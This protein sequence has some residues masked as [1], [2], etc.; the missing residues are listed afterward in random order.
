[1]V[2]VA[3]DGA[4][5]MTGLELLTGAVYGAAPLVCVLRDGK[6][7]Q[8]A[9]FQKIP[10]NRETCSVLPDYDLEH[11]AAATGCRYFRI[12]VDAELDSVLPAALQLARQGKVA[13][14][15]VLV[16][17]SHKTYFTKGVVRTNFWRL[18][19]GDR[20]RM[21]ARAFGRRLVPGPRF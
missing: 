1:V 5:R 8:I 10:L 14:V 20:L 21:L 11:L 19:W 17:Y 15:E 12:L 4:L 2:A 6:L 13:V 3:G 7:G 18:P 16:D 9:Q